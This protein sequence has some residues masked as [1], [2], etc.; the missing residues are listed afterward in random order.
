LDKFLGSAVFVIGVLSN[1]PAAKAAKIIDE[2]YKAALSGE[3][4][5]IL[6]KLEA[7][8]LSK[9]VRMVLLYVPL[10]SKQALVKEFDA[11]LKGLQ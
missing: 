5:S 10:A 1:S 4:G 8:G 6:K 9:K 7:S 11:K 2:G 3:L